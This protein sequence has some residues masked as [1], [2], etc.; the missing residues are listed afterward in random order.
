MGRK[1]SA[2]L[3]GDFMFIRIL[4][5]F[6]TFR[7]WGVWGS[8]VWDPALCTKAIQTKPHTQRPKLSILSIVKNYI[9]Q[10]WDGEGTHFLQ[11]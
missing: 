2:L 7:E 1:A 5:V 3:K 9:F 10:W 6:G 11:D 8:V 4:Q